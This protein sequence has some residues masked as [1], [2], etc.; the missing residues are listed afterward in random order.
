MTDLNSSCA[1]RL[2]GTIYVETRRFYNEILPRM[3]HADCGFKILYGPPTAEPPIMFIGYQPGGDK[4]H[5]F[6]GD[7][8]QW[9]AVCEYAT[10]DWPLA[11]ALRE[12]FCPEFLR[13]CVG[14]N[15]IFFRAPSADDYRTE[16]DLPL[17][18]DIQ[19]FCRRQVNALIAEMRPRQIVFIGLAAMALFVRGLPERISDT[20]RI[21][22]RSGVVAGCPSLGILHLTGCRISADDR[23]RIRDRLRGLIPT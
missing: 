12:V 19:R 9:P 23:V 2:A 21:L 4:S 8:H 13:S 15:G 16:L 6:E 18:N 17:R 22:V 14:T 10:A 3:G 11:K 7:H 1:I 20:S 5:D